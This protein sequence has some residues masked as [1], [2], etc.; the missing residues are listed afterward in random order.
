MS[1]LSVNPTSQQFSK[2]RENQVSLEARMPQV[3]PLVPLSL[4]YEISEE[5]MHAQVSTTNQT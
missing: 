4:F 1:Y 2:H 3:K 5:K